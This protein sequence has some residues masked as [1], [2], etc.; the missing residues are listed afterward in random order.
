[1]EASAV[2]LIWMHLPTNLPM[3][4]SISG[5]SPSG[6]VAENNI[7][8]AGVFASVNSLIPLQSFNFQRCSKFSGLKK[9]S[10]SSTTTHFRD[11][12]TNGFLPESIGPKE[13]CTVMQTIAGLSLLAKFAR[14]IPVF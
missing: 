10:A 4:S 14:D 1:M 3:I 9:T 6:N 5:T 7:H 11:F 2:T 8:Y 12:K 13:P